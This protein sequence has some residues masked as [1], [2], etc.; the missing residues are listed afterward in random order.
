VMN[1][2]LTWYRPDGG[3]PIEQIADEY[4][5]LLLKGLLR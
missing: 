4:A 5:D 3:K 2:T 1:W